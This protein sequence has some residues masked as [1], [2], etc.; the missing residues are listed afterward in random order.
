M[1]KAFAL[2]PFAKMTRVTFNMKYVQKDEEKKNVLAA[3][4]G[5]N[6]YP[7]FLNIRSPYTAD[8][9]GAPAGEFSKAI[10]Y[11]VDTNEEVKVAFDNGD[12][13]AFKEMDTYIT[14]DLKDTN[15]EKDDVREEVQDTDSHV[16]EVRN[17]KNVDG[18]VIKNVS[19]IPEGDTTDSVDYDNLP[20][21]DDY[22]VFNSN[23]IKSATENTG[24]FSPD[25][26]NIKYSRAEN[27][28]NQ[29]ETVV[30]NQQEAEDN[31]RQEAEDD[32]DFAGDN[33]VSRKVFKK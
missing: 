27:N 29:N 15:Y 26:N 11:D 4:Y 3:Q 21:A 19:D 13:S 28:N 25:T 9:K 23:Q 10:A 31:N 18:V 16:R 12:G 17:D 1:D 24:A 14:G 2:L 5:D 7:C 6:I 30:D 33:P 32:V 8:L 20:V 22:V